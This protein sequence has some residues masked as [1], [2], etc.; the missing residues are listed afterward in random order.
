MQTITFEANDSVT[1]INFLSLEISKSSSF[2]LDLCLLKRNG[3][4]NIRED[5]T[6]LSTVCVPL[7]VFLDAS[8]CKKIYNSN[9]SNS[10]LQLRGTLKR[11]TSLQV[12]GVD[13]IK[14]FV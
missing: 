5:L 14:Y 13:T 10:D 12:E 6:D 9:S 3:C 2:F 8:C 11:W 7:K 1:G 4:V